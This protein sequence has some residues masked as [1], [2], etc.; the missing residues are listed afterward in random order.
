MAVPKLL[1]GMYRTILGISRYSLSI[2]LPGI[3]IVDSAKFSNQELNPEASQEPLRDSS[4][5]ERCS[6]C[7]TVVFAG[8]AKQ[9]QRDSVVTASTSSL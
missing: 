4:L 8:A 5:C 1:Y 2:F 9:S 6:L 7:E 3:H